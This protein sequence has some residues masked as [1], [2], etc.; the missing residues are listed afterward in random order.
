MKPSELWN[1]QCFLNSYKKKTNIKK[2]RSFKIL[3][4]TNSVL[5]TYKTVQFSNN[6]KT[7]IDLRLI[8]GHVEKAKQM[9][10]QKRKKYIYT[11]TSGFSNLYFLFV[12]SILKTITTLLQYYY[13]KYLIFLIICTS[14]F[15]KTIYFEIKSIISHIH[16]WN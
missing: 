9:V 2:W 11:L 1:M 6:K 5:T 7:Y 3:W 10:C 16:I 12:S 8:F 15:F 4:T 14:W 13:Y